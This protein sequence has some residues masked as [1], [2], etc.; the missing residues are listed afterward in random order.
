MIFSNQQTIKHPISCIGYGLHSG[1]IVKLT[2]HPADV[3]SGIIFKRL[4]NG[5]FTDILAHYSSVTN[6]LLNTTISNNDQSVSVSTIEHLMAALWGCSID[7]LIIEIEGDEVPIMDGSSEH[8][9]FMIE[10]AGIQMQ[11]KGKKILEILKTIDVMDGD[12]YAC[13]KPSDSFSINIAIDF[14]HQVIKKQEAFYDSN[15]FSFKRD[16][17]RA[18][19]FG[20][21]HEVKKLQDMG[22]AKGGS[23]DN[24]IVVGN[25]R[26]L[27]EGGLRYQDEFVRHKALDSVG[28][29]YLAGTNIKGSFT[30]FK[31]GHAL[32]NKLLRKLFNDQESWRI[33]Q[34]PTEDLVNC[35]FKAQDF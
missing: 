10:S 2:M 8:F 27:N 20:F 1:N 3:D 26:V 7:N 5:K 22:L 4:K 12:S 34:L 21:E 28:D 29:L 16:L 15:H 33:I 35:N 9:V 31:S 30:G 17:S 14:D 23:L 32:N 11:N 19:T 25:D 13:L 18:R 24:A 6:T